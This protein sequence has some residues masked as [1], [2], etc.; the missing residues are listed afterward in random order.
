MSDSVATSTG[1]APEGLSELERTAGPLWRPRGS[2][3][4]LGTDGIGW[5]LYV[6]E[7]SNRDAQVRSDQQPAPSIDSVDT[8]V[9][10]TWPS[11]V[12]V[13]GLRLE[14]RVTMMLGVDADGL[15][16]TLTVENHSPGTVDSALFPWIRGISVPDDRPLRA[17]T[18]DYFGAKEHPL[19]PTFEW[20]KGYYGTIRPTLMTESLVFGNPTA[21]FAVMLDGREGVA[22]TVVGPTTE[23]TSWMW[24]LDPGYGDTVGDH[25]PAVS[26]GIHAGVRFSAVHLLDLPPAERRELSTI[27]LSHS[28]GGWQQALAPY[29][30]HRERT[31]A[32]AK[33]S[34]P[35]WAARSHTWYQVQL[36][37]AAGEER[38][39]FADLPRFAADCVDA[40]VTVLH[41]IGWNVGGQDRNNPSH[42]PDPALGG[43]DGLRAAIDACHELGVRVVLFAKFTWADLASQR[44]RDELVGSAI[45]DPNG[46]FYQNGG[47]QYLTPHQLLG[48]AVSRLIP[49]CYLHEDYLRVCEE[50]FDKIVASGADGMLFDETM[51][52]TPALL[53][54]AVDHGHRPGVSAYSGDRALAERL[55]SR[56]PAGH[57]FLFAGETIY[58]DLQSAYD[59]SYIRS[60][61]TAHVPL[62]RYA[63]PSLRMLT[64]VSGFDDRNQ[65]N[66]ALVY[67]YLLCYEPR[68][69]KGML[70]DIP[71]TVAYGRLAEDL[72]RDLSDVLW[73]GTYLGD[74]PLVTSPGQFASAIWTSDAGGTLCLVAN[75]DETQP[76]II[77]LDPA[78]ITSFGEHRTV[79]TEWMPNSGALT[80]PP[81]SLLILR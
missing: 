77:E 4:M 71:L 17:M 47:Y 52:H 31:A 51:H 59:M 7:G 12:S 81:R 34:P 63:N 41:V 38:F 57:E 33:V 61:Y 39:S 22:A 18:R 65:I 42:D 68:H 76:L 66:Q 3:W 60:H 30:A 37:S 24:E 14:I 5:V 40:G 6:P 35:S 2:E 62:T 50:E 55:R 20:N 78:T 15:R 70:A 56:V 45:L 46:D 10:W 16:A 28:A 73:N 69:F 67:G 27:V 58:E 11:V 29:R 49:M 1:V 19:W 25:V 23:I 13:T 44:F 74:A 79:E 43:P 64:T 72:R 80:V 36:N 26:S 32:G 53:C 75:F 54:Y 48:V 8:A 21:P 9:T